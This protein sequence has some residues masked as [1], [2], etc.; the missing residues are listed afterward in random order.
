M[1]LLHP[2]HRHTQVHA[3]QGRR[4]GRASDIQEE[5]WVESTGGGICLLR[6][7]D[8]YNSKAGTQD[9]ASEHLWS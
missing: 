6:S 4:N 5:S 2:T 8:V 3:P 9:S 7:K 1:P